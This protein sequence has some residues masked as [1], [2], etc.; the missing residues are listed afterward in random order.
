MNTFENVSAAYDEWH[1]ASCI[2]RCKTSAWEY[3]N[4]K[5]MGI[6]NCSIEAFDELQGKAVL[7]V[8]APNAKLLAN[9][10]DEIRITEHVVDAHLVYHQITEQ[11]RLDDCVSGN[12][13]HIQN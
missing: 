6:P 3:L 5:L 13:S 1:I 11:S 7:V 4:V 10:M 8:E 9:L 2:V 12:V